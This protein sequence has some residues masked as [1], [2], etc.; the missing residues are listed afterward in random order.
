MKRRAITRARRSIDVSSPARNASSPRDATRRTPAGAARQLEPSRPD[1][2]N[3][4]FATLARV[5]AMRAPADAASGRFE[6][7]RE[8]GAGALSVAR[9]P[10]KTHPR[11]EDEAGEVIDALGTPV[12]SEERALWRRGVAKRRSVSERPASGTVTRS[13]DERGGEESDGVGGGES[14]TRDGGSWRLAKDLKRLADAELGKVDVKMDGG[15]EDRK[16]KHRVMKLYVEAAIHFVDAAARTADEPSRVKNYRDDVDFARYVDNVCG[17]V[18]SEDPDIK[19]RSAAFRVLVSRLACACAVRVLRYSERELDAAVAA[20]EQGKE[21][22]ALD[23]ARGIRDGKNL[24]ECMH[25][26]SSH[27]MNLK[28]L[29]P[30]K[31]DDVVRVCEV[32]MDFASDCGSARRCVEIVEEAREV[33]LKITSMKPLEKSS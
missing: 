25:R 19:F 33:L 32:L 22:A 13:A 18:V 3:I 31:R 17:S 4:P 26:A 29:V 16:R 10:A 11:D 5:A 24:T 7:T 27:L 9:A 6:W 8:D 30:R 1:C 28:L 20:A 12:S 23:L 21:S 14:E 15:L 2:S